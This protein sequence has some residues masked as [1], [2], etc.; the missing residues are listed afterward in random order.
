[1]LN[2]RCFRQLEGKYK[3]N[4]YVAGPGDCQNQSSENMMLRMEAVDFQLSKKTEIKG[5]NV[6]YLSVFVSLRNAQAYIVSTVRGK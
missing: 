5:V 3:I 1:M 6:G 2:I 4:S